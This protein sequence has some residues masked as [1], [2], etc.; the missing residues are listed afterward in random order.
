M[1]NRNPIEMSADN[2]MCLRAS[3]CKT[4]LQ[5]QKYVVVFVKVPENF[6]SNLSYII[7]AEGSLTL[8]KLSLCTVYPS[9]VQISRLKTMYIYKI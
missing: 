5:K 1:A 6:P 3:N 8:L 9:L 4:D 2:F 7:Q